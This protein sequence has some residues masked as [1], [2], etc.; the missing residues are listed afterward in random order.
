MKNYFKNNGFSLL[1][2]L[3][4]ISLLVL[5]VAL[6]VPNLTKFRN[7]QMLLNTKESLISLLHQA[8]NNTLASKNLGNYGVHLS[9]TQATLFMGETFSDSPDNQQ[10]N[11]EPGVA[12]GALNLLGGGADI[13]FQRLSGDTN[14]PGTI[15]LQ[16]SDGS[17]E[18][19]ITINQIGVISSN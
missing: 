8:R 10:I 2:I 7:Q 18:K 17:L 4:T 3:I 11:F 16:L 12:I 6:V 9:A 5:I 1:E 19:I 15:Q 14:Q 13:V